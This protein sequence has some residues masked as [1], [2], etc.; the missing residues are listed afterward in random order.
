M[1]ST[2]ARRCRPSCSLYCYFFLAVKR[3]QIYD[4]IASL[5]TLQIHRSPSSSPSQL[6]VSPWL[7]ALATSTS[8]DLAACRCYQ[9]RPRWTPLPSSTSPPCDQSSAAVPCYRPRRPLPQHSASPAT[10]A[11]MQSRCCP[12]PV[13]HPP[14]LPPL[15]R[16]GPYLLSLLPAIMAQR[17]ILLSLLHAVASPLPRWIRCPFFISNRSNDLCSPGGSTRCFSCE[18]MKHLPFVKS[19]AQL[20]LLLLA[21]SLYVP[22]LFSSP[23]TAATR[24]RSRFQPVF[25]TAALFLHCCRPPPCEAHSFFIQ[26]KPSSAAA[27]AFSA[28][29]SLCRMVASTTTMPS[30]VALT[31]AANSLPF[32]LQPLLLLLPLSLRDL[33]ALAACRQPCDRQ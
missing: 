15:L 18:E 8:V 23:T 12:P 5:A 6:I 22:A 33:A 32:L 27:S 13:A 11:A 30:S 16:C 21:K 25:F 24:C 31:P 29:S 9:C 26:A 28:F 2:P 19:A 4:R 7:P 17:V 3:Q 1:A 20:P 14:S 10:T